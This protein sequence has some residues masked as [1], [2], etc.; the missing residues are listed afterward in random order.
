MYHVI[1]KIVQCD[2][3]QLGR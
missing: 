1:D 2:N 3:Y